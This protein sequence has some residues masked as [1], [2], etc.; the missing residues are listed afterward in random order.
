MAFGWWL[1]L[2]NFA[3]LFAAPLLGDRP[4]VKPPF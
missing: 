1:L 3:V 4:D 2:L